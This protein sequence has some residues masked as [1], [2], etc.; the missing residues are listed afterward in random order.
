MALVKI[1]P[2]CRSGNVPTSPFCSQCGVSLVAVAPL[3]Q[4]EQTAEQSNRQSCDI[5][6]SVCPDC[7]AEN[8]AG[9]ER[10]V[11]CDCALNSAGEEPEPCHVE[12]TWPW[13]KER[14]TKPLRIGR[15]PP[16][17]ESLIDAINAHGYDNISR[18]H[19]ELLP[20]SV[21]GGVSVIDLGSTNGTFVDGV[22]IP[23]NKPTVLRSGVVVRFAANLSVTVVLTRSRLKA[24][25]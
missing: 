6:R 11:Y 2:T 15:E 8:E 4:V 21:T 10:C 16:S 25:I 23:P 12:L 24:A 1:C 22:R 5:G 17:P 18:S 9:A 3:E 7:N 14:L 20:D 19:A 13:G